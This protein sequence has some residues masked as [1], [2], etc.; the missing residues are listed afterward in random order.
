MLPKRQSKGP[1]QGPPK[2]QPPPSVNSKQY[3]GA[4]YNGNKEQHLYPNE[5]KSGNQIDP[6]KG[7][8]VLNGE[9]PAVVNGDGK[10]PSGSNVQHLQHQAILLQNNE[11]NQPP[12]DDA[13]RPLSPTRGPLRSAEDNLIIRTTSRLPGEDVRTTWR[14]TSDEELLQR[15]PHELLRVIRSAEAEVN[16]LSAE[17]SQLVRDARTRLQ[18]SAAELR[19]TQVCICNKHTQDLIM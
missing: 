4:T 10:R 1:E 18:N 14:P 12:K 9:R 16:R 19:N 5:V 11:F 15:P 2:Y 8:P 6:R 7:P 3:N 13:V 17:H